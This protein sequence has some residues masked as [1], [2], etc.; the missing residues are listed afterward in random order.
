MR[1]V[2]DAVAAGALTWLCLLVTAG[3]AV[4]HAE[5]RGSDPVAGDRVEQAPDVF[6]LDFTE[7][8]TLTRGGMRLLDGDGK[9]QPLG[10]PRVSGSRVTVP[11]PVP[12]LGQ[13][14]YVLVWRVVSADSHPVQGA[15][16]FAVG[17]ADPPPVEWVAGDGGAGVG[18]LVAV[19][20]WMGY[21]GTALLIGPATLVIGC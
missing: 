3:P 12:G 15:V 20:R 2:P 7:G 1:R 9:P 17:T 19:I 5:L 21:A 14:A 8:V 11:V 6:Q 18:A 4:A 13:G 16:P 10:E